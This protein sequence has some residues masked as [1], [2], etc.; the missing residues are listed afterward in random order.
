MSKELYYCENYV[1]IIDAM[2]EKRDRAK[3][4]KYIDELSL[5]SLFKLAIKRLFRST[6]NEKTN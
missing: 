5:W 6:K 1:W 2:Q 4:Q 3:A